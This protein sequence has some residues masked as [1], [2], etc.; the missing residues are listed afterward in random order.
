M[1]GKAIGIITIIAI[2]F[3]F[4]VV[5]VTSP[6]TS[7]PIGILAVFFLLYISLTGIITGLLLLVNRIAVRVSSSVKTRRPVARLT[8]KRAYYFASVIALG[9]V[10][11]VGMGSV[12]K[13]GLVEFLLVVAFVVIGLF[14]VEKRYR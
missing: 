7:G 9:P 1:V 6:S 12:G 4:I 11:L 2:V 3:L 13:A 5:N 14:Y 10:M 8:L